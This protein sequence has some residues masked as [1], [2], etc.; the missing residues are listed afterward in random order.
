MCIRCDSVVV[1]CCYR[2]GR[3]LQCFHFGGISELF[4]TFQKWE[5]FTFQLY[6]NRTSICHNI[7][8][9]LA[10]MRQIYNNNM[11]NQQY[12]TFKVIWSG[13]RTIASNSKSKDVV[14]I[15]DFLLPSPVLITIVSFFSATP[16]HTGPTPN[17]IFQITKKKKILHVL[18]SLT[19][20]LMCWYPHDI[21]GDNGKITPFRFSFLSFSLNTHPIEFCSFCSIYC[22]SMHVCLCFF[23]R[24]VFPF[25]LVH[26]WFTFIITIIIEPNFKATTFVCLAFFPLFLHFL[27]SIAKVKWRKYELFQS[28]HT[29]KTQYKR[30]SSI[31]IVKGLYVYCV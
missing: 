8:E 25:H 21:I 5:K 18:C 4:S 7:I 20:Q 9:W 2:C 1:W 23:E 22:T 6:F 12:D 28:A 26:S 3:F 31:I 27:S 17:D 29:N 11:N 14:K 13:G 24:G 15:G 16:W 10:Y 30:N 19:N